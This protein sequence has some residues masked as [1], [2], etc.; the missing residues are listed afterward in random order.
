MTI[1]D[2]LK[3]MLVMSSLPPSWET[4]VTTMCSASTIAMKYTEVN[5]AILIDC[6]EE[7]V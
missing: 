3:E 5:N 6:S 4:F 1:E 2:E 7:T